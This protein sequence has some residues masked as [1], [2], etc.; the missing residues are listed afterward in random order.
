LVIPP[1]PEWGKIYANILRA[2]LV[3]VCKGADWNQFHL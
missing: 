2:P 3:P 1:Y